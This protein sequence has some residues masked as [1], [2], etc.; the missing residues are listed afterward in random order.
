MQQEMIRVIESFVPKLFGESQL[1]ISDWIQFLRRYV[2]PKDTY[3]DWELLYST[4]K[5]GISMNTMY[6]KVRDKGAVV[7]VVEDTNGYIF[8]GY[9]SESLHPSRGYYGTGESFLFRLSPRL[10]VYPWPNTNSFF[11]Y[12]TEHFISMGGGES[13]KYGLYI[14]ADFSKGTSAFCDTFHNNALASTEF[15]ECSLMEIWGF[16]GTG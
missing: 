4:E 16:R 13:G 6:S 1:L 14:D 15:F 8:G 5:H 9:A 11:V 2:S 12:T 3:E 7:I 10:D